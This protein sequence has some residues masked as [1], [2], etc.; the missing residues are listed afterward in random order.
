MH[1]SSSQS[2]VLGFRADEVVR[3]LFMA[4]GNLSRNAID[5]N[6]LAD[7][8]RALDAH[9]S[10]SVFDQ[11]FVGFCDEDESEVMQN[12]ARSAQ[13]SAAQ[14]GQGR[15]A[16]DGPPRPPGEAHRFRTD[17]AEQAYGSA[18][19]I[20]AQHYEVASF[21]CQNGVW[22]IAKSSLLGRN[23]PQIHFAV[24]LPYAGNI[25]PRAWAFSQV[26][27]RAKLM[28]LKHTNFPDASICAFMESDAAWERSDG[29]LPLI[30]HYS[31][32]ALKKI[33]HE[34]LGVWP[35]RQL[36][37]CA[38]YRLREFHP[39][40]WCGCL[41]GKRY[42]DCHNFTDAL[43]QES[44]AREEFRKLFKCDYEDRG[45]PPRV[46]QFAQSGWKAVPNF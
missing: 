13:R 1:S 29:I 27:K 10:L 39:D 14:P 2:E 30:D 43:T 8:G 17:A 6:R 23:G 45:V 15:R 7:L 44:F 4:C 33:H 37:S 46:L 19:R 28:S 12:V 36:G 35:G 34:E 21:E 40:E 20:L 3:E 5:L 38:Y 25:A 22:V 31:V 32:W 26:G 16:T 11:G 18:F 9:Q 24:A 41:S 42:R